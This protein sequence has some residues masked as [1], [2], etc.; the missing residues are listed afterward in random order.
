[1]EKS[2]VKLCLIDLLGEIHPAIEPFKLFG[3]MGKNLQHICGVSPVLR[4]AF[5]TRAVEV[6][7]LY[8][9]HTILYI[10]LSG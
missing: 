3:I 1:M 10:I 7:I 4:P 8:T 5:C 2:L 9:V 6:S